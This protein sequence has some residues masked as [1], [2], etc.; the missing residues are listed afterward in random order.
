ML[1]REE[2]TNMDRKI[3]RKYFDLANHKTQTKS[4]SIKKSNRQWGL[5]A[6]SECNE[7]CAEKAR[8]RQFSEYN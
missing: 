8:E 3:L 2:K 1:V 7:H 5:N 6:A 4:A